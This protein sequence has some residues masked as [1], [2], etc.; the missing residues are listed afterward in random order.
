MQNLINRRKLAVFTS[1][2]ICLATSSI[3]QSPNTISYQAVIRNAD[4]AL[5]A[6]KN[7]AIRISILQGN[8]KGEQV[9]SETHSVKTNPQ[10]LVSIAIGDGTS[11]RGGL[12]RIDWSNGPY[13]IKTETDPEG[14]TNYSIIG[15]SQIM[16]VPYAMHAK[17]ADNGVTPGTTPG[18]MQYWNGTTWITIQPGYT[19]Q[20]LVL[21]NG[22]PTWGGQGMGE[23]DVFNPTTGKIWMDRNLGASQVATSSTDASAYGDLYQ[24]GRGSDGHEKR[25]SGTTSTQSNADSPGHGDFILMLI[26]LIEEE[27]PLNDN[28]WQGVNGINN[29]CPSGYRVP[30]TAELE[31]ERLSWSNNDATGAFISPL[32]LTASGYRSA[33]FGTF[34]ANGSEGIYWSSTVNG[35]EAKALHFGTDN[36]FDAYPRQNGFSVRCIKD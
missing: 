6:D 25:T 17:T 29:P 20:V 21:V 4:N 13:F 16:T 11:S 15:V 23:N 2:Y 35:N 1:V 31:E 26:G 24:W 22:V 9:Y 8:E 32:K 27:S 12:E 19:G 33:R 28:L 7:V 30:T 34:N 18:Q 36:I 14:G 10:G 5:I 3:A